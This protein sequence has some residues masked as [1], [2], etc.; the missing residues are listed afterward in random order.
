MLTRGLKGV[1]VFFEDKETADAVKNL[2][3]YSIT[4]PQS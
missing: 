3:D 4:S 2:I 1:Y